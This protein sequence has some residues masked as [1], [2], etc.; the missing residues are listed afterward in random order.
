[1][2]KVTQQVAKLGLRLVNLA[3][4]S[5]RGPLSSPNPT[6]LV[7]PPTPSSSVPGTCSS[8][9]ARGPYTP[10]GL[11]PTSPSGSPSSFQPLVAF[12][13]L[14]PSSPRPYDIRVGTGDGTKGGHLANLFQKRLLLE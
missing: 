10:Q 14:P 13:S 12:L 5:R 11:G 6:G 8:Q 2:Y 7:L 1:M 9:N 3:L 4:E